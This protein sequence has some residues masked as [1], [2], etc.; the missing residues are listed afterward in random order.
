MPKK[1]KINYMDI[2]PLHPH[3]LV[4]TL[5]DEGYVVIE[6]EHKGIYNLLAQKFF[7]KPRVS[8]ITLDEYGTFVFTQIDGVK[9]VFD[10]S[11]ALDEHFGEGCHPLIDRLITYLRI[12]KNNNFI[13]YIK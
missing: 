8:F 10:I 6:I 2:V 12:L 11:V 3:N 5:N 4:F 13:T 9:T 1:E 7:K